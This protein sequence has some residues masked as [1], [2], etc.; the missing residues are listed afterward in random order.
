[1]TQYATTLEEVLALRSENAEL[2][3]ALEERAN[4]AW[5]LLSRWENVARNGGQAWLREHPLT[6]ETTELLNSE[7]TSS[8]QQLKQEG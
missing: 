5:V 1:M 3:K 6:T 8:S 4:E 7:A 2:R